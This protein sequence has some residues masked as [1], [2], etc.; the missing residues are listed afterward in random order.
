MVARY[1]AISLAALV[2]IFFAGWS[3]FSAALVF[4]PNDNSPAFWAVFAAVLASIAL[5]PATACIVAARP[6]RVAGLLAVLSGATWLVACLCV[7]LDDTD[8]RS[9]VL[10]LIG[11]MGIVTLA[12]LLR[13]VHRQTMRTSC[14]TTSIPMDR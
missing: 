3:G 14:S 13:A 2:N 8:H 10:P 9:A 12:A 11:L 6:S 1:V 7:V 5:L 4:V